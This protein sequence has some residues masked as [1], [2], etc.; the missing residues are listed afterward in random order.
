MTLF[1]RRNGGDDGLAL[2][3]HQD[4]QAAGITV[5]GEQ[6]VDTGLSVHID[7]HV[8]VAESAAVHD[9]FDET[10]FLHCHITSSHL[11]RSASESDHAANCAGI[12][13]RL[14]L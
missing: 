6:V 9:G 11:P 10:I 12:R 14:Y 1:F 8:V 2:P 4:A 3:V 7:G 13:I 5:L